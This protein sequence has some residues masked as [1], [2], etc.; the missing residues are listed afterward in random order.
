M[1]SGVSRQVTGALTGTGALIECRKVGFRPGN[2]KLIC[3][4]GLCGA[5]WTDTMAD[6][7]C[8][9]RITDGTMSKVTST[10]ITPLSDGF[11]LGA[12]TDLNVD[13]EVIHY[14]ATE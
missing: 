8:L 7:E 3:E 9:K 12:D 13:G 2:V 14:I 10:G 5:E 6:G 11:S 1:G 4:D